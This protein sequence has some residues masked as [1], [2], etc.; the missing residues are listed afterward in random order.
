MQKLT[1]IEYLKVAVANNAGHDKWTWNE[2]INWV[3]NNLDNLLEIKAEELD[4]P[5]QYYSAVLALYKAIQGKPI[6]Y[7]VGMDATASGIQ[8]ISVLTRDK[9]A[10]ALCNVINTGKREDIYTNI[11]KKVCEKVGTEGKIEREHVKKAIMTSMYASEAK[12][13]QIFGEDTP[14]LRAFY[15]TMEEELPLAWS[16]NELCK[17]IWRDDIDGYTI[18]MPDNFHAV[19]KVKVPRKENFLFNGQLYET[20]TMVQGTKKKGKELG[21]NFTHMIDSYAMRELTRRCMYDP[22]KVHDI[23][24]A[25]NSKDEVP[26][27][28]NFKK[29]DPMIDELAE[30]FDWTGLISLR[31]IDYINHAD[32]VKYIYREYPKYLEALIGLLGRLPKRPFEVY[33][34]H[35][36]FNSHPNY[37][38]DV[39]QQYIYLLAEV[40]QSYLLQHILSCY[41]N[42]VVTLDMPKHFVQDILESEYALS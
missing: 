31:L 26:E 10:A 28:P 38:N 39:R 3:D 11:Y 35:D 17:T 24:V 23:K 12:P 20:V 15:D 6:G 14:A 7:A 41:L 27:D 19:C 33:S 22:K 4:A 30:L 36:Q 9:K 13:K 16:F 8:W 40:N 18:V 34:V 37:C 29:H 1:S 2:R 5:A 32:D 42:K 25:I 21:A